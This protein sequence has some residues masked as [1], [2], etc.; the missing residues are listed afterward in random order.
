M[1]KTKK[2][3]KNTSFLE[4]NKEVLLNLIKGVGL[5][6]IVIVILDALFY[7]ASLYLGWVWYQRIAAKMDAVNLNGGITPSE[8][9]ALQQMLS[10]SVS[11]Y[12]FIIWSFVLLLAAI[13][14]LASI[15]KGAIWAITTKTKISFK[16]ISKFLGLNLIWMSIWF[17]L[18][19]AVLFFV[20]TQ[21]VPAFLTITI[22]L[23]AYLTNTLYSL[24]MKEQ[25]I[26]MIIMA[27]KPSITKIHLLALPYTA[28]IGI[29]FFILKLN[30]LTAFPYSSIVFNLI[31]L[32]YMAVV[33]YYANELAL[34]VQQM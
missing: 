19:L 11:F 8:Y 5:K 7:I 30:T 26:S 3:A 6:I 27:L 15:L 10:E 1:K 33:R 24:F 14:F 34:K 29:F 28:V 18:L 13:I 9:G 2:E 25:K 22:I 16:L 20:E 21:A 31:L 32:I 17:G 12:Y 4:W 23:S